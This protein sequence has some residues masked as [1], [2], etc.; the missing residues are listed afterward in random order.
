MT[1]CQ[2][3]NGRDWWLINHQYNS[4]T[5]YTHLIT[6]DTIEGPFEQ[7]IGLSGSEADAG[8]TSI[9]SPVSKVF[10]TSTGGM[11]AIILLDFD[12]C[13]GI[14]S[15]LKTV[16]T[17]NSDTGNYC[18]LAFSPNGRFLYAGNVNG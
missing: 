15:N 5:I 16:N 9:F 18:F 11:G 4:N 10:A 12:R 8:G 17:V 7:N 2:H 6:P 1:A 13:S 14:F 3:G